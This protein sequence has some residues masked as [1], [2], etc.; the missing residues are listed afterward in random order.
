MFAAI[1]FVAGLLYR[2]GWDPG[3]FFPSTFI[4]IPDPSWL[5]LVTYNNTL[6]C[7]VE[8]SSYSQESY[9]HAVNNATAPLLPSFGSGHVLTY[10]GNVFGPITFAPS[11][12]PGKCSYFDHGF[13]REFILTGHFDH[14]EP[15]VLCPMYL[16]WLT[17]FPYRPFYLCL[18]SGRCILRWSIAQCVVLPYVTVRARKRL[19][20]AKILIQEALVMFLLLLLSGDIGKLLGDKSFLCV[21]LAFTTKQLLIIFL[22]PSELNPGPSNTVHVIGDSLISG[23]KTSDSHLFNNCDVHCYRGKRL[24][25]I[26]RSVNG[27]STDRWALRILISFSM[28]RLNPLFVI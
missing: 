14:C 16:L 3:P 12:A 19:R 15:F 17:R 2:T 8:V 18:A 26:S 23:I 1:L 24:A 9:C 4:Q 7:V 20:L 13:K 22:I 21:S 27:F 11:T 6:P 10:L 5:I 25:D 28:H